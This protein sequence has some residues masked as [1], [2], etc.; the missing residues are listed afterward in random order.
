MQNN[1]GPQHTVRCSLYYRHKHCSILSNSEHWPSDSS[2][3]VL[4]T[5]DCLTPPVQR[6]GGRHDMV[7]TGLAAAAAAAARNEW[8][9]GTAAPAGSTGSYCNDRNRVHVQRKPSQQDRTGCRPITSH[10][11][12]TEQAIGLSQAIKTGQ[13]RL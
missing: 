10:H 7:V 5:S 8:W 13:S 3:S 12:R 11:N 1:S 4:H 6:P 2:L 9:V